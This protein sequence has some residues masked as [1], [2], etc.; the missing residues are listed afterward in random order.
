MTYLQVEQISHAFFQEDNW[1]EVLRQ[2]SFSVDKGE[3]ISL[4]G[5]SG[6]GKTTLLSIIAGLLPPLEGRISTK[7]SP[8]YMLQHDYLFPWK[9]IEENCMLGLRLMGTYTTKSKEEIYGLLKK[10]GLENTEKM[11][12]HQLSGGMRQRVALVRTLATK[13]NLLL[14]DEPFSALDYQNKL[15]LEELVFQLLRQYNKTSI[16]VTHDIEEAIAMSDRIFLLST[17]PGEI[18]NVINVPNGIRALSPLEARK[19]PTFPH[20]FEELWKEMENLESRKNE[21]SS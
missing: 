11:Y 20:I 18:V 17:Q 12:P 19:H 21:A 16:L 7:E 1:T 2:I 13:P 10:V 9:T 15:K 4:L 8:G 3:F 6:C 14:L 5:P